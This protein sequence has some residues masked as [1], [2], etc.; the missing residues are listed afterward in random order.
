MHP[1]P[2]RFAPHVLARDGVPGNLQCSPAYGEAR[3]E[4][5]I[6][7]SFRGFRVG[8]L[9]GLAVGSMGL[10]GCGGDDT[11]LFPPDPPPPDTMDILPAPGGVRRL[12]GSQITNSVTDLL[13][14]QAAAAIE[15]PTD[16]QLHGFESI[17]AAELTVT[18]TEVANF[19]ATFTDAID[20]SLAD[21]GTVAAIAPCVSNPT[22]ACYAE[23]AEK[24][25]R[26][27]WR[28]ALDND[29]LGRLSGIGAAGKTW[30]NG[31]FDQ[32]LKYELMAIMQSPNFLYIV[33]VGDAD[34][35]SGHRRLN[36]Y[37]LASRMSFF[38]LNRTP[39]GPLLDAADGSALGTDEGIRAQALRLLAKPEAVTALDR[40]YG[41]LYFIRDLSDVQKDATLYPEY[42]T[43]LAT[44]M[45]ESAY[46]FLRDIV[47]TRN[48]D[49]REVFTSTDV[50][51]DSTTAPIYGLTGP[52]QGWARATLGPDQK[53]AGM[54]GQIPF[55]TRF[56]HPGLTSPTRRG[57]FIQEKLLCNEI[58]PPPPGQNTNIPEEPPGMP[59]TMK[60]K[61]TQH[62][63]DEKCAGCH[64][65]MDPLGFG[66]EN[67]DAIGRFRADDRGLPLDTTGSV[68][69]LGSFAS[70]ADIGGLLHDNSDAAE[71]MV[72][73]FIRGSMGH[74]DTNGEH[75]A[76][77]AL[78][79]AFADGGYST[80]GIM[81][82]LCVSP[83]F[84]LVDEPK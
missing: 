48:A 64:V 52:T 70:S 19:E 39:D 45:Q 25:G 73:N 78:D 5:M 49:A 8:A 38:L 62:E 75:E 26:M 61:L 18:S 66:L 54:I 15:L 53:R 16:P 20:A 56:A 40:Y 29:E 31:D 3:F 23:V 13:G 7:R 51:I 72:R 55:L 6:S 37:E 59:M 10:V 80:K 33:E 76:V 47:W 46:Q 74:L 68:D 60:Q 2:I 82:E 4:E 67:Y 41:E 43:L 12:T 27:A 58:P 77:L 11:T 32:G 36:Q 83:A 21:L 17:A 57:R 28:R 50:F 35:A 69:N 22:D 84:R 65:Q 24:F 14:V 9:V 42:T 63:T 79:K 30:A 71:C 44:S 81:A 1:F 34:E